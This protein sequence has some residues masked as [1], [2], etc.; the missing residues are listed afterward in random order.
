[1]MEA[2]KGL[3]KEMKKIERERDC[4]LETIESQR[5]LDVA[6]RSSLHEI[7]GQQ[8]QVAQVIYAPQSHPLLSHRPRHPLSISN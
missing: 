7:E 5:Q 1:V 4:A 6:V 3:G 8:Q 2:K